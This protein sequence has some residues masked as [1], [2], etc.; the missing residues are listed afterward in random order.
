MAVFKVKVEL[1]P[2]DPSNEFDETA[3]PWTEEKVVMAD[4]ESKAGYAV[5]NERLEFYA[6]RDGV[7]MVGSIISVAERVG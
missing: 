6:D 2:V 1:E 4:D 7:S 5:L 3:G